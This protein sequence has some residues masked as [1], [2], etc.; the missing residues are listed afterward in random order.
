PQDGIA[1][2]TVNRYLAILRHMLRIA[3]D[4]FGHAAPSFRIKPLKT[5][6]PDFDFLD[7]DE[8]DAL[9]AEADAAW[10]AMIVV[11]A[12]TGLRLGEL[13]GLQWDCV[14]FRRGIVKVKRTLYDQR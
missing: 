10:R 4:D 7:F 11:A 1:K 6:T 14:D 12:R 9:I 5:G 3:Q 8:A 13:R 2:S